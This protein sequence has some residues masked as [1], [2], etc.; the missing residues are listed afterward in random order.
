MDYGFGFGL[1]LAGCGVGA[2]LTA[3]FYLAQLRK[4]KTELQTASP[5]SPGTSQIIPDSK[6]K[7]PQR[8]PA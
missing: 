6:D 7:G 2:L 8:R 3:G 1:L 5:G 4:V